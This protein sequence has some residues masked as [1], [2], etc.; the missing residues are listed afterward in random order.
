MTTLTVRM[1]VE[2]GPLDDLLYPCHVTRVFGVT[3]LASYEHAT[4]LAVAE[5]VADTLTPDEQTVLRAGYGVVPD[6]ERA[7]DAWLEGMVDPVVPDAL[8]LPWLR[9][10]ARGPQDN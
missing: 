1:Y 3:M 4:K 10:G 6:G 7:D 8:A 2:I 9:R 5:Y